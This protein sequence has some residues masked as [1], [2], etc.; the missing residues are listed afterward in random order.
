MIVKRLIEMKKKELS[1]RK[2]TCWTA[3]SF[4]RAA[5][6][7]S[8]AKHTPGRYKE[9]AEK[10]FAEMAMAHLL[11]LHKL[12]RDGCHMVVD[13]WHF[14]IDQMIEELD[15]KQKYYEVFV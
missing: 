10:E 12:D 6:W 14:E 3:A 4:A 8:E 5:S 9:G 13:S 1:N 7:F 2:W 11:E 15:C